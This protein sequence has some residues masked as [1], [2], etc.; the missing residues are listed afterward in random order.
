MMTVFVVILG[1]RRCSSASGCR[2]SRRSSLSEPDEDQHILV[3][4]DSQTQLQT[5][6]VPRQTA[7]WRICKFQHR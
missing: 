7:S 5:E 2:S 4:E 6:E 1:P 3:G